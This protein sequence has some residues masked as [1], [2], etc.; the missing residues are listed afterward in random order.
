MV[1]KAPETRG[2]VLPPGCSD[3][4]AGPR[5]HTAHLQAS[6]KAKTQNK[7][8]SHRLHGLEHAQRYAWCSVAQFVIL[9]CTQ[10]SCHTSQGLKTGL[11]PSLI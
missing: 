5:R 8:L 3:A 2:Q 6:L 4:E 9:V 11:N 1:L 10:G 7:R